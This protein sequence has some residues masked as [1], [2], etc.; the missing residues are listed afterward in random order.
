M[1]GRLLPAF[2]GLV[3]RL[4]AGL[5]AFPGRQMMYLLAVQPITDADLDAVEAVE[6]VELGQ[7]QAVDAAGADSLPHQHRVEP[8]AAALASGVDA[9]FL[10]ATADQLADLV[11]EF[12]GKRPH[13]DAGGIGLADTEHIA[14]RTRPHAGSGRRLRRHRVGR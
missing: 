1:R 4:D 11:V 5:A 13:A 14:D 8:A 9:E 7:R 6:N 12:G 10:A 3:D 2:D